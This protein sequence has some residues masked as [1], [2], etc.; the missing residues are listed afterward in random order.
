MHKLLLRNVHT[1]TVTGLAISELKKTQ[2][3]CQWL[4]PHFLPAAINLAIK[5]AMS[6]WSESIL[7]SAAFT[8]SY[9]KH[10][11]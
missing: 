4:K 9:Y 8:P 7:V 3:H 11:E 6:L 5:P 1:G 2:T 10:I